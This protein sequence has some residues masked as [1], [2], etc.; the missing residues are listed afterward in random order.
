[1]GAGII[2]LSLAVSLRRQGLKVLIIERGEPG[3]EASYAAAGMLSDTG[4]EIPPRLEA[5]A[6]ASSRLYPEFVH[7]LED[8]SGRKIDLREQGTI[9]FSADGDFP[10]GAEPLSPE[11]LEMIEPSLKAPQAHSTK[12][13]GVLV[14]A[15]FVAERSLD[16]RTLLEAA[17]K[18]A[19]HRQVDVSSG[20]EAKAL[21]VSGDRACGVQTEKSSYA[22]EVVVNCAGAWAGLIAPHRLPIRPI[23]GQMLSAIG[24]QAPRHVLRA[25]DVYLVPRSDGR[26]VIG[27]TV[28]NAGFNKQTDVNTIQRLF[29]AALELVPG[30]AGA[31]LHEAWA[32][33][34][35]AAPDELPV[36]GETRTGGYLVA[37]GHYRDGILLAPVTA[38]VMSSLILGGPTGHDLTAFSPR[39]FDP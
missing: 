32:G 24:G 11:R 13:G 5:L 35:P 10:E 14:P 38:R 27:S 36:V 15:A 20:T 22:A 19:H 37:T 33:L 29:Q 34:R 1:M 39:R 9:L 16:P 18:A 28:E 7:E 8:E 12:V 23:K 6:H 2:G 21:L 3:R 4:K 25:R 30:L 26:V 17:V 31:K